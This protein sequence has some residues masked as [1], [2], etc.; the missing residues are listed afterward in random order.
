VTLSPATSRSGTGGGGDTLLASQTLGA[1]GP[2]LDTS[3]ASLSGYTHLRVRALIRSDNAA[4]NAF[5]I[6][7][8]ADAGANYFMALLY[9]NGVA[10]AGQAQA[11]TGGEISYAALSGSPASEFSACDILVPFYASATTIKHALGRCTFRTGT[12]VNQTF[13]IENG[14]TWASTAAV[15]RIQLFAPNFNFVT[16]SQMMVYGVS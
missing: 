9:S 14:A 2:T 7:F 12:G 13:Y 15:T 10:Q 11:Q 5:H 1:D 16:G 6:R 3:P 4:N 8:N